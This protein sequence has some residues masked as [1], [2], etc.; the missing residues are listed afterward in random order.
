MLNAFRHHW[1]SHVC[2]VPS[3]TT[4]G[5][6][7]Q[8]LSASLEFSHPPPRHAHHAR[9]VLNAFRHHWNSHYSEDSGSAAGFKCS[10]PFGIIGILT[11]R[12]CLKNVKTDVLNA[13]R[14]H[15]NSHVGENLKPYYE[16]N[17]CSTPF[18]IIGIL[19]TSP[20]LRRGIMIVCSTPFGIIGILTSRFSRSSD[21]RSGAQRLSASLEFSHNQLSNRRQ[22]PLVLNAFRHHWNSHPQ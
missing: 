20:A 16:E 10:T 1:N 4:S 9:L 11:K 6:C 3:L 2:P 21:E 5:T 8:R 19:T 17:G 12:A 13:F 7:A 22:H 15:W 14:H 18:G